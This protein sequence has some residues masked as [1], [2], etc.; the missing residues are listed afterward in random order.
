MFP[1]EMLTIELSPFTSAIKSSMDFSDGPVTVSVGGG[2]ECDVGKLPTGP[3]YVPVQTDLAYVRRIMPDRNYVSSYLGEVFEPG[4][5]GGLVQRVHDAI[6]EHF[7]EPGPEGKWDAIAFRGTS[8]SAAAFPLAAIHGWPLVHVRKPGASAHN[9]DSEGIV[10]VSRF[11]I[12]DDFISSGDTI[13]RIVHDLR[14][15]E[16]SLLWPDPKIVGIVLFDGPSSPGMGWK[17]WRCQTQNLAVELR[18]KV[19]STFFINID[20]TNCR[21]E[22]VLDASND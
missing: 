5:L 13:R 16:N 8:G 22:N 18:C 17:D 3:A 1:P 6:V 14:K 21:R 7:G 2:I 15:K 9:S 19:V 10:G 20:R 4:K 12:V 11:L